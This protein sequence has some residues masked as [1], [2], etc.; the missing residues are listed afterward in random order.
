M[1][2]FFFFFFGGGGGW[3]CSIFLSVS[4]SHLPVHLDVVAVFVVLLLLFCWFVWFFYYYFPVLGTT[5][6]VLKKL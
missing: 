6:T 5:D 2:F 1:N 4:S 3:F